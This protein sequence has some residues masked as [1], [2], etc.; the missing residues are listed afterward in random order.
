MFTHVTLNVTKYERW[1]IYILARDTV[2]AEKQ[3]VVMGGGQHKQA[4]CN[5]VCASERRT[6]GSRQVT[7]ENHLQTDGGGEGGNNQDTV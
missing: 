7:G 2:A 3:N 4:F 6:I 5:R 1:Y